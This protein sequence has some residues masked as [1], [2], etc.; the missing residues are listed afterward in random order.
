MLSILVHYYERLQREHGGSIK[1][2]KCDTL[3]R[4]TEIFRNDQDPMNMY[5]TEMV[6]ISPECDIIY[7]LDEVGTLYSDWYQKNIIRGAIS[8][9]DLSEDIGNSAL[10][11]Y[12]KRFPDNPAIVTG[13]RILTADTMKLEPGE[14]FIGQTRLDLDNTKFDIDDNW[15][16]SP[17]AA[18]ARTNTTVDAGRYT[19]AEQTDFDN[20]DL[21]LL[22]AINQETSD[23]HKPDL[24]AYLDDIIERQIKTVT[25]NDIYDVSDDVSDDDVTGKSDDDDDDDEYADE[26]IL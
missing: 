16:E 22:N 23:E 15:W 8:R 5:I 26:P 17:S 12:I 24:D 4:E 21:E 11:K 7:S 25:I 10:Q 20:D 1:R 3:D 18:K 9:V 2:V 13:I 6:V 19:L 14:Q